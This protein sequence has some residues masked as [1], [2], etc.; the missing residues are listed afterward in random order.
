MLVQ[1]NFV[2]AQ[3]IPNVCFLLDQQT[4]KNLVVET[5]IDI[6]L[7]LLQ[8]RARYLPKSSP[9]LMPVT[10]GKDAEIGLSDRG[11]LS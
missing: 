11:S 6:A 7:G 8:E 2:Q 10:P 4:I 1:W 9:R 5:A 3:T